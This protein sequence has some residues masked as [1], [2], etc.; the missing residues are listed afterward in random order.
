[1]FNRFVLVVVLVPLAIILIALAVANRSRWLSRS[2]RSILA[3]RGSRCN[4]RCFSCCSRALVVGMI[5]GS[6]ATW[7]KQGRYRKLAK[8]RGLEAQAARDAAR[9]RRTRRRTRTGAAEARRC[10]LRGGTCPMLMIS[11]D[12]VD[13]ALTFEGLVETLRIAFRD[14]A[15]QPVRHHHTVERPDGAAATLLLMPAWTDFHA[16]GVVRWRSYR[17]EDRHRLAG[18]QRHRQAGGDGALS[19]ARRQ[20]RRAAGADRRAAADAVAH[21]ERIRAGRELSGARG[22][23]RNCW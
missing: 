3:T 20:D 19:A 14:G 10:S 13:R 9:G 11:A 18:Q 16:A 15:V 1:M 12:D 5:I 8:Q 7:F 22:R 23:R 2:I 21:G 6:L 4:C 17:R